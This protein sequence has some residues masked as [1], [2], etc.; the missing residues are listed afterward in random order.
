MYLLIACAQ[1]AQ[2]QVELT[3]AEQAE[4]QKK[5]SGVKRLL[6]ELPKTQGDVCITVQFSP[7]WEDAG[8]VGNVP[9]KPLL[10]W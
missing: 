3:T 2:A 1:C 7:V 6:I 8:A 9:V 4:P 5:N 10:K